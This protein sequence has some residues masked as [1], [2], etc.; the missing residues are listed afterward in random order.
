MIT[1]NEMYHPRHPFYHVMT[2]N[3]PENDRRLPLHTFI[4]IDSCVRETWIY[5][6]W[7]EAADSSAYNFTLR[8][9][10]DSLMQSK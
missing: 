3:V 1:A 6:D 9:G 5:N 10:H 7:G 4:L 2:I 8:G